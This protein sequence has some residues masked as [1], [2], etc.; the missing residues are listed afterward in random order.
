MPS[1]P[2]RIFTSTAAGDASS[3]ALVSEVDN[4]EDAAFSRGWYEPGSFSL[5]IKANTN[6]A[7]DFIVDRFV[8]FGDLAEGRHGI[9][10]EVVRNINEGGRGTETITVSGREIAYIFSWR[11][12]N[13]DTGDDRYELNDDV[14]TVLKT[15]VAKQAGSTAVAARQISLLAIATNNS[16]GNTFVLSARYSNL[17]EEMQAA[18]LATYCGFRLLINPTTVKLDFEVYFGVNRIA[19]QAVNARAIFSTDFDTLKTATLKNTNTSFRNLA[20]V[21]GQGQGFDRALRTV[22]DSTEPTGLSR[23]EMFV[24][25][26][27]L[28]TNALLDARGGQRL[29]EQGY[30]KYLETEVAPRSP[31]ILDTGYTVGDFVTVKEFGVSQDVQI[32]SVTE[33]WR[34]LEYDIQLGYSR[35]SSTIIDQVVGMS[36]AVQKTN[37]ANEGSTSGFVAGRGWWQK[38]AD[39]TLT[40]WGTVD[41]ASSTVSNNNIGTY[42]WSLYV[43]Q[44]DITLPIAYI[45]AV[46]SAL[47]S[48]YVIGSCLVLNT[49]SIRVF[50]FAF[51]N[52]TRTVSWK[53]IGRWK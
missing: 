29:S 27:D 48:S 20:Y 42:G 2:V 32:T 1:T 9:I 26:R 41:I 53:T 13:P 25:A 33:A 46:Y 30:T 38:D 5:R 51:A 36:A 22:Y 18:A 24:D 45:D 19:S 34:P 6:Y 39:G 31:L 37:Q 16:R 23:R 40:Q 11:T 10:T 47:A 44:S 49:T 28:A 52:E 7:T 8:A 15:I 12:V 3:L 43:G 35:L 21:A 4:Y 50:R 14:E 17:L